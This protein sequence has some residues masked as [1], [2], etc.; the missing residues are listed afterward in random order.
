MSRYTTLPKLQTL[1][2]FVFTSAILTSCITY[3]AASVYGNDG[4]YSQTTPQVAQQ[5][6]PQPN[7]YTDYFAE[8]ANEYGDIVDSE[9]FTDVDGYYSDNEEV[10][11]DNY[12]GNGAWGDNPNVVNVNF[13][14]AGYQ[15]F[16]GWDNSW[17]FGNQL[18]MYGY[19]FNGWGWNNPWGW[20]RW[21]TGWGWN[22][23]GWNTGWGWN[24][25]WYNGWGWNTGWRN[26]NLGFRNRYYGNN[27][28]VNASR[29]GNYRTTAVPA[30]QGRTRS[31]LTTS[32]NRA[33]S[34]YRSNASLGSTRSSRSYIS[35]KTNTLRNGTYRTSRSTRANA[36]STNRYISR[37]P[38]SNSRYTTNRSSNRYSTGTRNVRPNYRTNAP[39]SRSSNTVRRSAPRSSS[40]S[41]GTIRRSSSSRSSSG[42]NVRS[43]S[44]SSRSSSSGRSSSG[45]SSRSSRKN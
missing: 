23:F 7:E 32:A 9:V 39:T 34:R 14:D 2:A 31:N 21:N 24:G 5:A 22:N 30:T 42:S 28:A 43:S 38:S 20:N 18:S 11:T 33:S 12:N 27:Y 29:R 37:T 19:G 13:Y 4:I 1:I 3:Q 8:K 6:A 10:G 41:S 26:N 16:Y 36:T 45:G 35:G 17:M 25:G 15:G 40:R 44:S